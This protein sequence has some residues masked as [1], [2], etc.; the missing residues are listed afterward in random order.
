MNRPLTSELSDASRDGDLLTALPSAR[1]ERMAAAAA[2]V[3][4]C[5]RALAKSGDNVVAELLSNSG[6]FYEWEHYPKGDVYDPDSHAQYYYHAHAAGERPKE[7]GHFHT[8]LRQPGM[9]ADARP[10]LRPGGGKASGSRGSSGRGGSGRNGSGR[11]G[12]GR[13]GSGRAAASRAADP[14]SPEEALSHIVGVGIDRFGRARTLFTTNRWVTG[15]TWYRATDVVGM[16]DRFDIELAR[17]SWLVNRWISSV[18]TLFRPQIETLLHERDR[19]IEAHRRAFPD[20]DVF[21][22]RALEV[23]SELRIDVAAQS[24]AVL[25]ALDRV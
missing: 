24:A 8:F 2:E 18:I 7:H 3:A 4:R 12:S 21:E 20:S 25:A 1:L 19:A 13:N 17:P 10:A 6:P 11:N 15:E 5:D 22:D 16:I 14:Q 9:P 23:T